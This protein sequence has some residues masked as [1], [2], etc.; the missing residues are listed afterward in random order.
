MGRRIER[1]Q[2][3]AEWQFVAMFLDEIGDVGVP[4]TLEGYRK[5]GKWTRHRDAR[6]ERLGVVEHSTGLVPAGHHGDPVVVF[7]GD[8]ALLPQRLV[9]GV[10]ILDEPFVAE[11][12]HLD[13]VVR[14][15]LLPFRIS[16][17]ENVPSQEM[18]ITFP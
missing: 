18:S 16:A 8:G 3:V 6:R 7:P 1:G 13:E 4:Q 15:R 12:V 5:A 14:H 10:G 9:V 17:C 2:L 11:K